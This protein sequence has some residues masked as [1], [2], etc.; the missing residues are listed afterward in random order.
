MTF[1]KRVM[2]YLEMGGSGPERV[3]VPCHR[4]SKPMAEEAVK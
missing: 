1:Q 2:S 4:N 3:N